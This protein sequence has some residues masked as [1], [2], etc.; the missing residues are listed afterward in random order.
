DE[1]AHGSDADEARIGQAAHPLPDAGFGHVQVTRDLA[2]GLPP[3][4]REGRNDALVEK[5]QL[6]TL[7]HLILFAFGRSLP[8]STPQCVSIEP[9]FALT[10]HP[11]QAYRLA[12]RN[13]VTKRADREGRPCKGDRMMLL[14]AMGIGAGLFLAGLVAAQAQEAR[15]AKLTFFMFAGSG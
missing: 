9:I 12:L 6:E 14:R 13:V 11:I 2:V 3:V 15:D 7:E 8:M 4:V 10:A 1:I 5:V